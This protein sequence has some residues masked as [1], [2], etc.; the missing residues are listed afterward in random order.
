MGA[1]DFPCAHGILYGLHFFKENIM[2]CDY[3][4]DAGR[5][6]VIRKFHELVND[7]MAESIAEAKA[8]SSDTNKY[9]RAIGKQDIL[10]GLLTDICNMI[11]DKEGI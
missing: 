3:A 5:Q 1:V 7:L 11:N 6:K 9:W 10:L 2:G 4:Y 8:V